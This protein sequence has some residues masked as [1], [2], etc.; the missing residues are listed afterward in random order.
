MDI[1]YFDK[2]VHFGIF[3][4]LTF[5]ACWAFNVATRKTLLFI[6][7]GAAFYGILVELVQDQFIA[8]RSL[9]LGDWAADV[10]GSFAG[11]WIWNLRY[12]KK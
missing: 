12:I 4:S 7:I 9:D 6:F 5:I 10:T 8:N 3:L 1:I 11:V 2:W